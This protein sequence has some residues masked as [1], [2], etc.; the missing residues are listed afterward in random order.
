[1]GMSYTERVL[2]AKHYESQ[3]KL[4]EFA[5]K[6]YFGLGCLTLISDIIYI[7]S[8]YISTALIEQRHQLIVISALG[9][10]TL[11]ALLIFSAYKQRKLIQNADAL[12]DSVGAERL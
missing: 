10:I 1:M 4:M 9:L 11:G 2:E 12:S 8:K 6:G 5:G 7:G 3:T